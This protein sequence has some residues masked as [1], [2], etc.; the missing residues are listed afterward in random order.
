M[1]PTV[2]MMFWV[3]G[4][5]IFIIVFLFLLDVIF[6]MFKTVF[7]LNYKKLITGAGIGFLFLA[8]R[9]WYKKNHVTLED[10]GVVEDS[11]SVEIIDEE[12]NN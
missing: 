8:I 2:E 6:A 11:E 12:T 10:R 5:M 4:W 9:D 3:I 1:N 7:G